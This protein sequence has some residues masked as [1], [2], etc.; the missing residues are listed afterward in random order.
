MSS[1][2]L[3]VP[4]RPDQRRVAALSAAIALN[5]FV[6]VAAMRPLA[7]QIAEAVKVPPPLTL[8]WYDPPPPTP[9]PPPV[10]EIKPLPTPIHATAPVA[11]VK[12]VPV[13][14]PPA[15]TA[16]EEGNTAAPPVSQP[17]LAPPATSAVGTAPIEASLAYRRAPLT[18]PAIAIRAHMQ[19]T[20]LLRVLVD[21]TGKPVQVEIVQ[22]SGYPLLDRS[23]KA[24]V[25]SGW[26]FQ[27]ATADGK[28]VRAWAK[29]PVTFNLR[30]A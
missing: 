19:G 18:Y 13:V 7:P 12:A 10:L 27:P 22:G 4:R 1:A 9:P 24:Q 26:S 2:S 15:A 20:V 16:V 17:T 6:L 8:S 21:E 5:L 23:A 11:P 29:V 14:V 30:G 28:A 25:L 3:A